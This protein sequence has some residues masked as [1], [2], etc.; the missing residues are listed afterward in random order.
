MIQLGMLCIRVILSLCWDFIAW[1]YKATFT[2]LTSFSLL[3]NKIQLCFLNSLLPLL[4]LVLS[5]REVFT[6]TYLWRNFSLQSTLGIINNPGR[7]LI[8][9]TCSFQFCSFNLLLEVS[10]CPQQNWLFLNFSGVLGK[11]PKLGHLFSFHPSIRHMYLA[12]KSYLKD[13]AFN[14]SLN[15]IFS[16]C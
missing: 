14:I 11:C 12:P 13:F 9:P 7:Q 15:A 4:I 10:E 16:C 5:K 8:Y 6:M 1:F 3:K 2:N